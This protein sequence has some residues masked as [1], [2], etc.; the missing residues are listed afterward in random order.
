LLII[1]VHSIFTTDF[2]VF[3]PGAKVHL[4]TLWSSICHDLL[5]TE[6]TSITIETVSLF[7]INAYRTLE[8][9]TDTLVGKGV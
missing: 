9:P 6:P 8:D 2:N 3:Q 7:P 4:G 5:M 1:S